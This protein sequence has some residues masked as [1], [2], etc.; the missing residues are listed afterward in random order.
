MRTEEEPRT[1]QYVTPLARCGVSRLTMLPPP[2]RLRFLDSLL[3]A[4]GGILALGRRLRAAASATRPAG[5]K[6][7]LHLSAPP[8]ERV[9]WGMIGLGDRGTS[10]LEELL[11]LDHCDVTALCDPD[12]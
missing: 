7:V 11:E 6:A 12:S 10:Q 2:P 8:L 4:A 9:R 5:A 3:L 1:C